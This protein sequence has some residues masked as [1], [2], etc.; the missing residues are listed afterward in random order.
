[1]NLEDNLEMHSNRLD[2]LN[3]VFSA[4]IINMDG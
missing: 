1:M 2:K 3:A 4:L